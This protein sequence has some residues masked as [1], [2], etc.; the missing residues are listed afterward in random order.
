MNTVKSRTFLGAEILEIIPQLGALRIRVFYDFPYLY[1]GDLSYEQAYLKIYSESE[2]SIVYGLFDGTTLVGATTGMPLSCEDKS[3][4]QPFVDHDA[5]LS[6]IFYF[7]ESIL[8]PAYRGHGHGHQF[9]DVRESHALAHGYKQTVFC[10]VE[11]AIHHPMRPENYV[12]NDR[13]WSKRGYTPLP[14]HRCSLGWVDRGE[15]TETMK[16]LQFWGKTWK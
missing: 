15:E 7:G 6:E 3:I 10:S 13:F 16:T 4:Q 11:R 14:N 12:P 8:L 1:A 5:N 2:Q 9:F